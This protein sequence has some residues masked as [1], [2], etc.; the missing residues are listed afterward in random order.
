MASKN[1]NKN[2]ITSYKI[3]E[4]PSSSITLNKT[5][6]ELNGYSGIFLKDIKLEIDNLIKKYG[7]NSLFCV[8][9]NCEESIV[10]EIKINESEF[11]KDKDIIE[12]ILKKYKNTEI[13]NNIQ[14]LIDEIIEEYL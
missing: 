12:N 3:D 11:Q 7:E 14:A 2:S 9:G 13:I 8:S 10:Y 6:S 5:T 4:L 1:K